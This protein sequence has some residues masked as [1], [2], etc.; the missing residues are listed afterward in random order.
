LSIRNDGTLPRVEEEE[1]VLKR[2]DTL[3][4]HRQRRRRRRRRRSFIT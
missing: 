1:I 4:R 2:V 3:E